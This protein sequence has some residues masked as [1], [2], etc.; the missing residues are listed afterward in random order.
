MRTTMARPD[1]TF[2]CSG[3]PGPITKG[4]QVF[5]PRR[6]RMFRSSRS[7]RAGQ[8]EHVAERHPG[9]EAIIFLS[10]KHASPFF[11]TRFGPYLSPASLEPFSINGCSGSAHRTIRILNPDDRP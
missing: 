5:G 6:P 10:V 7:G 4:R 9:S 3:T 11:F 2:P 8:G 1:D